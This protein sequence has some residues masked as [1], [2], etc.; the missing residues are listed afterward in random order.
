MLSDLGRIASKKNHNTIALSDLYCI[1]ASYNNNTI[2]L[3]DLYC[4][5]ASYGYKANRTVGFV[6]HR[7]KAERQ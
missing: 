3:S 7:F 1:G 5:G 4:I 6:S 2:A